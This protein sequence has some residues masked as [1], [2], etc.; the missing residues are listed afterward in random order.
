MIRILSCNT[1]CG[2]ADPRALGDTIERHA[3][4]IVCAQELTD[5]LAGLIAELLPHGDVAQDSALRGNG[6][7]CRYPV[8]TRRIPIQHRSGLVAG[9]DTRAPAATH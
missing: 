1:F 6:I 2:Q 8:T 5:R 9:G 4:D 3:V 7:A